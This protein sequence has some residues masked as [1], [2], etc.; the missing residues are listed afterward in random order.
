M[1]LAFFFLVPSGATR[2]L[3]PLLL[4]LFMLLLLIFMLLVPLDPVMLERRPPL[5][6]LLRRLAT[7][8][9]SEVVALLRRLNAGVLDM[10][11]LLL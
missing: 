10:T 2:L 8:L 7:P 9:P 6:A 5:E 4:V 3:P 1:A 11:N